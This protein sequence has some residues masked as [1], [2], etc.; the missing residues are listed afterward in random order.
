MAHDAKR[1]LVKVIDEGQ[2]ALQRQRAKLA[3]LID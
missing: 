3:K 1:D 2:A